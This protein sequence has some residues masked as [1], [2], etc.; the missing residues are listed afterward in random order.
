MIDVALIST[1]T[2]CPPTRALRWQASLS[3]ACAKYLINTPRRIAAF[4]S[5]VGVESAGLSALVENLNYSADGLLAT[6]PT[7]FDAALA[8]QYARAPQKIANRVYAGRMGNGDEASGDGWVYRGRGLLQITG[9]AGYAACG[10]ALGLDLLAHPEWLELP[11]NAAL[12]AAWYF[13]GHGC[14]ALADAGDLRGVTRAI[15]GGLN[16]YA[17]RLALFGAAERVLNGGNR[18]AQMA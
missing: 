2:G 5:Q 12:S 7:H 3:T 13:A 16:G 6:F 18:Y 1:A 14:L 17:E 8:A 11:A 15:N 10:K 4:L 9:C